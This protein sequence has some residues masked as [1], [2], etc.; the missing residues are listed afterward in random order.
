MNQLKQ[1]SKMSRDEMK[2]S[3]Y[4]EDKL[5]F[6]DFIKCILDFQLNEHL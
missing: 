3:E 5:L 6:G 2:K 1:K 4:I